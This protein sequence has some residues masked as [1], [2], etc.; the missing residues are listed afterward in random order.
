MFTIVHSQTI[1]QRL[2]FLIYFQKTTTSD[3][4][5]SPLQDITNHHIF[6]DQGT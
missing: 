1:T 4:L 3:K 6:L 5:E 2:M